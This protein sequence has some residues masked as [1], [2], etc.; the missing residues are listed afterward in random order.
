MFSVFP[1]AMVLAACCDLFS[2]TISNRLTA[3]LAVAFFPIALWCGFD[4]QTL[5]MHVSAGAAMLAIGFTLFA[6][7]WI[8]GGDAKLFAAT[9]L[10]LGW[11]PL[12]EYALWASLMG[13][14]LTIVILFARGIPLPPRL[15][16]ETWAVRLHGARQGVP[17][18]I[19]LAAA[20]LMIYP[21]LP[22]VPMLLR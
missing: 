13:G 5:M 11:T 3:G 1:A 9:A 17:Y 19:A 8:G 10:W 15:Q 22:L 4:A 14:V 12:F 18:G 16:S 20:G 6:C 21:G 7:G 2:M